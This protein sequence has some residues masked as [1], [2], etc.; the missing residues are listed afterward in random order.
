MKTTLDCL[1]C[2]VRQAV[3]TARL[4]T[5]DENQQMEIVREGLRQI[6]GADFSETPPV[7]GGILHRAIREMAG[8]DPFAEVKDFCN[9]LAA[10]ALPEARERVAAAECPFEMAVRF[11]IAGNSIDAGV[12]KQVDEAML[13]D[14]LDGIAHTPIDHD[15]VEALAQ[16]VRAAKKILVLGD[17]CGEIYFDRILLEEMIRLR[18]CADG[19]TYAVRGGPVINDATMP[20]AEAAGIP[21]LVP[22]I[23]NGDDLPGTALERCSHE[24]Q[25]TFE[26]ADLII[27]KGQ[28]NFETLNASAKPIFFLLRAKCAV[29]AAEAGRPQG[30]F[31][32]I[33]AATAERNRPLS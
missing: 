19:I 11:A 9:A 27:S 14:A 2:F 22:V 18:N 28:G 31:L 21:K 4:I 32:V 3:D 26:A 16:A 1:P 13:H 6:C 15:G 33:D 8:C 24:F 20:D 5:S 17:N 10:R 30:A 29:V 7:L 25:R 23:D 12:G